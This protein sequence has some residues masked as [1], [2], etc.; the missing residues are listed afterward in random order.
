MGAMLCL[1]QV[2]VGF[3]INFRP[4]FRNETDGVMIRT[5]LRV[6]IRLGIRIRKEVRVTWLRSR[7]LG[8]G[9]LRSRCIS[10][11]RTGHPRQ[12]FGPS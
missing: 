2:A 12:H 1:G 5:V 10:S 6:E 7:V 8:L 3:V 11:R 9:V 4:G